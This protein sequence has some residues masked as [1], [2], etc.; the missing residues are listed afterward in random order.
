MEKK[1]DVAIIGNDLPSAIYTYKT[2]MA[3]LKVAQ[4]LEHNYKESIC[5]NSFITFRWKTLANPIARIKQARLLKF[6]K[7][8]AAH[9]LL[10]TEIEEYKKLSN[11]TVLIIR[12]NNLFLTE[13]I[14]LLKT[15]CRKGLY[16]INYQSYKI[17]KN[18][19]KVVI[20]KSLEQPNYN[21]F[22]CKEALVNVNRGKY[23]I[24]VKDQVIQADSVLILDSENDYNNLGNQTFF[25]SYSNDQL[26]LEKTLI[27]EDKN[28]LIMIIPWFEYVHFEISI[29]D[30]K[31]KSIDEILGMIRNYFP[32][33][34]LHQSE[35]LR[36]GLIEKAQNKEIIHTLKF[37]NKT[38]RAKSKTLTELFSSSGKLIS[39]IPKRLK[40]LVS[41][42]ILVGSNFEIPYHPLRIMEY[43]DE[44][45][46]E[47]KQILRSPQYFKKLFYRYG[48]EIDKIT[49]QA[50]EYWNETKDIKKT[51]LKAEI[52]YQVNYEQCTSAKG[53]LNKHTEEWM[54][55]KN[56]DS[57]LIENLFKELTSEK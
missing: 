56:I 12:F 51:W 27:V 40:T 24:N 28:N 15:N 13:P 54:N 49:Y 8:A 14:R 42:C 36:S 26:K 47:A 16:K 11:F 37:G 48:T 2:T 5:D 7:N 10:S 53:F 6:L 39:K 32:F 50:Y 30:I 33:L 44:K 41:D 25:I 1:F 19:L 46:D 29:P 4:I 43:C 35:I 17:S 23:S 20:L 22:N 38:F 34:N 9:L 45:Y 31:K 21:Q 55:G 57:K 52:W 18:R 3:G